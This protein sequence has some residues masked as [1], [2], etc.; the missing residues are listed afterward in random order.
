MLVFRLDGTCEMEIGGAAVVPEGRVGVPRPRDLEDV[1]LRYLRL[2]G[3]K[4]VRVDPTPEELAVRE[5]ARVREA[6]FRNLLE[7]RLEVENRIRALEGK[8]PLTKAQFAAALNTE[9]SP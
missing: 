1:P 5:E 6:L 9:A 2:I 7:D 3:G 4:V 8:E